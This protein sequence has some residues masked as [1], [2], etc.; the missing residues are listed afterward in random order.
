VFGVIKESSI[1][2]R[3]FLRIWPIGSVGFL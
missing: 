3:V 2:G 1:V